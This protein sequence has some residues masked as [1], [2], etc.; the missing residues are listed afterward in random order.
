MQAMSLTI[1]PENVDHLAAYVHSL[2]R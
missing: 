2:T 1:P